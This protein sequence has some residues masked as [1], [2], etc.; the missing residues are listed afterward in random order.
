[1]MIRVVDVRK[2]RTPEERA[3]VCYVGRWSPAGWKAHPLANPFKIGDRSPHNH[4]VKID[5]EHALQLYRQWLESLDEGGK[6]EPMLAALWEECEH[7]E[8]ALGCWC[9]NSQVGDGQPTTC[10]AEILATEL[11]RRFV[12]DR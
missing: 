6:L 12:G 9:A 2:L 10:H 5:R 7:G 8:R 3:G 11:H 4:Q 1:M